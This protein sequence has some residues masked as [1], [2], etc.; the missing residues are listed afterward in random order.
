M[1]HTKTPPEAT[2]PSGSIWGRP[3]GLAVLIL[4]LPAPRTMPGT[5]TGA[6]RRFTE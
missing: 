4:K 1:T 5:H 6:P 2:L 3:L